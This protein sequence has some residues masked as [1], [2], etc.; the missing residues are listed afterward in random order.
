M[1]QNCAPENTSLLNPGEFKFILHRA[2]TLSFFVQTVSL[3]TITLPSATATNP[4]TDIPYPGDHID[5]DSLSVV[6]LVDEDLA[7]WREMYTWMRGLGFPTTFDEYSAMITDRRLSRSQNL[8]SDIT[9]Y[10]NT[11]S[12][13]VNIEYK[14][15]DCA[16][17]ELSAPT[18]ST[19][20]TDLPV[21]TA[22]ARFRYTYFEVTKANQ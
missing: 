19:T 14:F 18:L 16:P 1:T 17:I 9:I 5:W 21:V 11:G 10:T 2:P 8:E 6:F 12:R 13:N 15:V 7:G 4:F 20:Y 3:P 22:K